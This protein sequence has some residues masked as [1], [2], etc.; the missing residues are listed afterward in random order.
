MD[1]WFKNGE[2]LIKGDNLHKSR[3]R[4]EAIQ[5]VRHG[6]GT[7]ED[8]RLVEDTDRVMAEAMKQRRK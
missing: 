8:Y 6:Q 5:R 7:A 2:T 1:E 3:E 4:Y